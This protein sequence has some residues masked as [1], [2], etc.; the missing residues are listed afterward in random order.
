M[1][2]KLK[3]LTNAVRPFVNMGTSEEK[4]YFSDEMA[5][6]VINALSNKKQV[7]T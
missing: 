7:N 5:E 6:K 1:K 2:S 4:E 3:E